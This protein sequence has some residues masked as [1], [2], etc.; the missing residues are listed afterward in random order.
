MKTVYCIGEA[1]I[2]FTPLDGGKLFQQNPGGAPANV[3]A[4][5]AKLGGTSQMITQVGDDV[6]GHYLIDEMKKN[7]VDTKYV[8]T[9]S[10]YQ[11]SLAFVSLDEEGNRSFSFYRE[12]AADLMMDP[13]DYDFS[14][15]KKDDILHFCSVNLVDSPSRETHRKA[16]NQ[17]KSI[18]GH[19][20]FDP[21]LRF[22][23]WKDRDELK[24]IV[25]EFIKV[26]NILKISDEEL[27][28]ITGIEDE[29]DALLSLL[30]DDVQLII[31]TKG[32]EGIRYYSYN[33]D[34]SVD[35][36]KVSVVDTTGA[37]D[38]S[39]GSV[40]YYLQTNGINLSSSQIEEMLKLSNKVAGITCTNFGGMSAVPDLR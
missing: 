21:N 24:A 18:G 12:N 10:L 22:P 13:N 31:Y 34:I 3:A 19:I 5:V 38:A 4:T 16:I 39:I 25:L 23:L 8:S 26:S 20:S 7:Y 17:M 14:M 28:F 6:F 27:F 32:S 15:F 37:G 9:S 1:L 11:T 40:L 35:G 33:H 36:T 29:S 2:D 30:R